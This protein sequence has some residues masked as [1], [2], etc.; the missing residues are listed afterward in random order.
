MLTLASQLHSHYTRNCNLYYIP[1][2]RT[3]I[4]NF[5]IRFQG[6]QFFNSLSPER[7]RLFGKRLRPRS[8]WDQSG[9]RIIGIMRVS[10]CLGA[11]L[12]PEHLD[13]HSGYSASRSRIAG[14]YSGIYS[15]S[16]ITQ[17]NAPLKSPFFLS[18]IYSFLSYLLLLSFPFLF[19]FYFKGNLHS[20]QMNHVKVARNSFHFS[21]TSFTNSFPITVWFNVSVWNLPQT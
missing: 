15:Y 18:Q 1:P 11:F 17:T 12:I 2:C 10:V 7:I 16:G 20:Y 4:R 9:I 13:F 3:N 6:P 14:I 5:S 19:S 8:F 21:Q